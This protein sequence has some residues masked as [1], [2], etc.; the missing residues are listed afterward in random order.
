MPTEVQ[1][2]R[3]TTAQNNSFTGAA[4]ELSVNT[5]NN[6]LRIHDGS[7]AGG[8][9]L[10][11][12]DLSNSVGTGGTV[13]AANVGIGTTI[14]ISGD[15]QLK[16]IQ[17]LDATTTATIESAVAAAPNDFTSL[18]ISGIGTVV[19]EFN[20]G[21]GGTVLTGLS[22][23][24]ISSVG[25]AS[26]IPT[27]TLD[28]VGNA[29]VSETVTA[30]G[31]NITG[32]LTAVSAV[33]TDVTGGLNITGVTTSTSFSGNIAGTAVTT[34]STG[35]HVVGVATVLNLNATN[36]TAGV[37]TATTF[38]GEL[39]GAA[40]TTTSSGLFQNT[41]IATI[42]Q[43]SGSLNG[44]VNSGL[45]TVTDTLK[46]SG[47]TTLSGPTAIVGVSTFH[48][49]SRHLDNVKALF[50]LGGDLEIYHDGSNSFIADV[51][52]GSLQLN[53]TPDIRFLNS[54][55]GIGTIGAGGL[56]IAGGITLGATGI[57]TLSQV[58]IG[59]AVTAGAYGVDIA[60]GTHIGATGI[61]TFNQVAVGAAVTVNASGVNVVGVITATTSKIGTAVTIASQGID[62]SGGTHIGV[63]GIATVQQTIVG[64][65]QTIN[66]GGFNGTNVRVGAALTVVGVSTFSALVNVGV[67]T[68]VGVVMTA[69]NGT[70]Y[71]LI[72]EDDGSLST[73]ALS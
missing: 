66:A 9:E 23:A 11:K 48:S 34:N 3:G 46:V 44:S 13:F 17:S 1:F 62:V 16:N 22:Q 26:A 69:S 51:G 56:D 21:T 4:G 70:R 40:V 38:D 7:T 53:A 64:A 71:R 72:V 61:S 5:D 47:I 28:V 10:A 8:F 14:V 32:V 41:G 52:G 33:I 25:I 29:K 19:G 39:T 20:V 27:A 54:N 18:S 43:V 57:A 36:A 68:S 12:A 6:S 24:G 55:T 49:N 30:V 60:G 73:V 63:A 37:I 65:A 67:D 15:F 31:G 35:L 50:G 45:T 58:K 42:T 2:R 59:A